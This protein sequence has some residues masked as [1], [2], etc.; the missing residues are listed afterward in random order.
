MPRN[1]TTEAQAVIAP[2]ANSARKWKLST[3][4]L[5]SDSACA[6]TRCR[7]FS[8]HLFPMTLYL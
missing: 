6:C 7:S 5:P 4:R 8:A 1:A 2:M 3:Q